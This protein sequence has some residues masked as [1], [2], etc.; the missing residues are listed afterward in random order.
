MKLTD[1][2]K[3]LILRWLLLAAYAAAT[4][5]LVLRH[6]PWADELQAAC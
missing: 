2:A 5:V 4:L 3:D 1:H 6:E